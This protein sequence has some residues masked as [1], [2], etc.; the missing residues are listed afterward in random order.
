[1]TPWEKY[2]QDLQRDDF[3]YDSAQ[4]N[5]VKHLQR[6]YDDLINQPPVKQNFF[7]RLFGKAEPPKVKGLYFWGGVGRGKTYLVDT[8]YDALPTERKMRVHFHRFMHRVHAE[9]KKLNEVKNPLESIADTFKSETDIICF[10]EF[11]VQDITDAMLLGGLMQALFARGIVL[12]ATSNIVPDDLYKN[13]LQRARFLPAIELV[14][15]NTEVVN[16]DSGIDYRLR[17]LEQ[18]EIFHSPLDKQ[19]DENLFDYFNKLSP[20]PGKAGQ[21]I[22]IEGRMIQTRMVSDCIVMF[23]FPALCETARS[24]VDYMEISRLYNTVILS[25]VKQMGQQND[26]AARRFIAL[27]DEFYERNV[28]LIISAAAPITELY[29]EGTLNFEFKRCIS[30]LQ[31]MQSHEYLAREHL[32]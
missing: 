30:R 18:A 12:V 22:E 6:L 32:A 29:T 7:S 17:T 11:F 25:N 9:L 10:D 5:A 15:A 27:V 4:E 1:M 20:E 19:A 31:E 8:F 23:D 21:A 16:V 13:G 28:T 3:Q 24:Q 26:D 2:Q 14:K